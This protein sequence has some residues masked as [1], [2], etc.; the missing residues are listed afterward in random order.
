MAKCSIVKRLARRAGDGTAISE[1]LRVLG[2]GAEFEKGRSSSDDT[3]TR[4][5]WSKGSKVHISYT[6]CAH[7]KLAF[8]CGLF[9][10]S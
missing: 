9:Y 5:I 8:I 3:S 6:I 1:A 4:I 7:L 2:Y 10:T